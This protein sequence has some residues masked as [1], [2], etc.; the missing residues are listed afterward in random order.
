MMA[1][2]AEGR[3]EACPGSC[4]RQQKRNVEESGSPK[5]HIHIGILQNMMSGIPLTFGLGTLCFY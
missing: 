2:V 3:V 5:K 1:V 4:W